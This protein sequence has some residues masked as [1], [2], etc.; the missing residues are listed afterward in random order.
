MVGQLCRSSTPKSVLGIGA[1]GFC[2]GE[3]VLGRRPV[4]FLTIQQTV[5]L[6]RSFSP[7][8]RLRV[9]DGPLAR[10]SVKSAMP[11]P[12]VSRLRW[13]TKNGLTQLS[14]EPGLVDGFGNSADLV[15][16]DDKRVT[17]PFP[18]SPL[19]SVRHW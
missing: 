7:S 17:G 13:P 1:A 18:D 14:C 12:V 5:I 3:D 8:G 4:R 9:L 11:S 2:A 15:D 6:G 19:R 10:P 16:L